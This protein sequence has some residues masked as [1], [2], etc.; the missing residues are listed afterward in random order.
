MSKSLIFR[1]FCKLASWNGL[2]CGGVKAGLKLKYITKTTAVLGPTKYWIDPMYL[3]NRPQPTRFVHW[4]FEQSGS[5][6]FGASLLKFVLFEMYYYLINFLSVLLGALSVR[7]VRLWVNPA[8]VWTVRDI[9]AKNS[10]HYISYGQKGGQV[11]KRLYRRAYGWFTA[12][13]FKDRLQSQ[14]AGRRLDL[15]A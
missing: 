7:L 1:H 8:L 12:E 15:R 10:R 3:V 6:L 4:A 14:Q 11:R 9:I 5:A 2:F 13:S